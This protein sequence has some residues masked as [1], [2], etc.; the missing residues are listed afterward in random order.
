MIKKTLLVIAFAVFCFVSYSQ[1]AATLMEDGKKLEQ[2]FKDDEALAKY[3]TALQIQPKNVLAAVKIAELNCAFGARQ[4]A[5]DDLK[6]KFYAEA[7]NYA[8]TALQLD[9]QSA[10]ANYINAVVYGKLTEVDKKNE[11][12][13]EDVRN[14]KTYA[15]K[16]LS[17]N[18]D[19]GKA[20][21]V[22]GKW[23]YEV[24]NLNA[25][26]KAALKILYGGLPKSNID[27][28]I[29]AYEK[30]KTLEPYYCRNYL[31]LAKAYNYNKQF[32]KALTA[33][34]QCIK[35]PT[36]STDDVDLKKEAKELLVKW[37]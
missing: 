8:A 37:Q 23:H 28:C 10:D 7:K 18:P 17:I 32:E 20:W 35:S 29:A 2:R 4:T 30:C 5:N 11:T 3:V 6:K 34:Q 24:L 21:N 33:L 25:V 19:Y 15:D 16:T 22:L 26:K 12:V 27:S 31:D 14:I 9:P 1:D 13:V 36:R